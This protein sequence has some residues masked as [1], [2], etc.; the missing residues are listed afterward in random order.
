VNDLVVAPD[1]S[2]QA[3]VIGVGGF[4]GIGEKNVALDFKSLQF[5]RTDDGPKV[6]IRMS[7]AELQNAP[8]F[9]A[10]QEPRAQ[11]TPTQGMPRS[12]APGSN[13]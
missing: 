2:V 11:R 3:A 6:M 10:Y 1:G 8:D 12:T 7:K 5:A 13:R 9:H 4:L